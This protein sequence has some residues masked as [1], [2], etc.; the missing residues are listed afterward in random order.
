MKLNPKK[1][2]VGIEEGIF[3]G[4]KVNTM[5]LKVCPDKVDVVLSLP[6]PKC[7]KEVQKLNE[8]LASLN[9][10]FHWTA[11]AEEAFKQMK[12][13]IAEL[14]MLAAPMEKVELSIY[15][16]VAKET[17]SAILMMERNAKQ[18]TIYFVSMALRDFIV[19]RPKEDSPNTLMEVEEELPE[20]WILFTDGSSCT[21]GSGARLILT[22]PE[23]IEFTYALRFR[24]DATNNEAEYEALIARLRIAKQI[25]VKNLQKNVDSRL[26]ANQ[27]FKF[28]GYVFRLLTSVMSAITDVKHFRIHISQLSVI[29]AAKVSHFEILCRVYGIIPTVGLFWCFYVNSKKSGWMSFS[30]RSDNAF[31]CYTKPLDSFK[32]WNDHFFWVDDFAC[33]ASFSW[34]TAKHVTRDPALVAADF[35]AQDYATLVAYPLCDGFNWFC[36]N[37]LCEVVNSYYQEFDFTSL[38]PEPSMQ[39]DP[40]VNKIHGSGSSSSTSIRVFGESSFGRSTMKSANICTLTDTL[41][42]RLPFLLLLPNKR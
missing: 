5:G 34:H 22:N 32:H 1:C 40:S 14:S 27:N 21:D 26:V 6:S 19:E 16:A 23:R 18:M 38:D 13:L 15:L 11:K 24:F 31:V 9:S 29:G 20:P 4:Y 41:G 42:S 7:L 17:V 37:P 25:C 30:K 8:K 35:N 10:D 2:T 33:P 36:F 12:Q 39:D 28:S 3:L